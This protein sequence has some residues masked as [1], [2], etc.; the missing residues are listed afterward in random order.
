MKVKRTEFRPPPQVD[1]AVVRIAP[2]NPPPP[3]NFDEW[4]GMLRLCFMRKNKTILS[5]VRLS[6]VNDLLEENYRRVC[7]MKNKDIPEDL[8]FTELIEK[9]LTESG[10]AEKRARSMKIDEFLQLLIIFNRIGVH[11]HV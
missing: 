8:N 9:A 7:R 5:I 6:N 11:F 10:F 1:S 4:E 2:R 3:L